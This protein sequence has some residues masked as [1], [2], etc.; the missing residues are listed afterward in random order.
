MWDDWHL[1]FPTISS[2][3]NLDSV[4]KRLCFCGIHT[5]NLTKG[6]KETTDEIV[7]DTLFLC[8]W[9]ANESKETP[10]SARELD[11]RHRFGKPVRGR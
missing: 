4:A 2:V 9:G 7:L 1:G 8:L 5:Q 3:S 6:W 10:E 11:I